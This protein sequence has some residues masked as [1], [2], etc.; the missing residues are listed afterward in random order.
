MAGFRSGRILLH[1]KNKQLVDDFE[2]CVKRDKG[3]PRRKTSGTTNYLDR[4]DS[5]E[6]GVIQYAS[7]VIKAKKAGK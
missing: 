2:T 3:D 6:Q 5:M 1:P 4:I 7:I